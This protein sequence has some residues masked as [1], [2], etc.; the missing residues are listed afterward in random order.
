M[1]R[2]A[3]LASHLLIIIAVKARVVIMILDP[4]YRYRLGKV[5]AAVCL[6]D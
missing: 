6:Q 4:R 2:I 5:D 3:R 1:S